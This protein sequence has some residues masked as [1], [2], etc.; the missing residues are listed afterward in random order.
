MNPTIWQVRHDQKYIK[1][2]LGLSCLGHCLQPIYEGKSLCAFK[3]KDNCCVVYGLGTSNT[4]PLCWG[5]HNTSQHSPL[6]YLLK[7]ADYS[8][9]TEIDYRLTFTVTILVCQVLNWIITVHGFAQ[10][11][12]FCLLFCWIACE[13]CSPPSTLPN[14]LSAIMLFCIS[15]TQSASVM[16]IH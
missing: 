9:E 3:N 15:V 6:L 10:S 11:N 13:E 4:P 2:T 8:Q 5:V 12:V 16:C 14:M 7:R 1:S